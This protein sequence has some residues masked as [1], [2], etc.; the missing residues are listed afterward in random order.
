MTTGR[1]TF[2]LVLAF[3]ALP[4]QAAAFDVYE[5]ACRRTIGANVL[6]LAATIQKEQAKCHRARMSGDLAVSPSA[7]CND[8]ADILGAP[9]AKIL[10]LEQKLAILADLKCAAFGIAPAALGY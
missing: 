2:I 6:K 9:Q 3:V 5:A 1:L 10:K 4:H 7:D 8:P